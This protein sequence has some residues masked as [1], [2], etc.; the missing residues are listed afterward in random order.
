[1][2]KITHVWY[3]LQTVSSQYGMSETS[4]RAKKGYTQVLS[5]ESQENGNSPMEGTAENVQ[6][7]SGI[8]NF[9]SD[10]E[11]GHVGS[12]NVDFGLA[13]FRQSHSLCAWTSLMGPRTRHCSTKC[14]APDLFAFCMLWSPS[15]EE[16]TFWSAGHHRISIM[17]AAM[18]STCSFYWGHKTSP[19]Y[20]IYP[21]AASPSHPHCIKTALETINS[22]R[23]LSV[24][25][26]HVTTPAVNGNNNTLGL[27]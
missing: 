27:Q 23:Y 25:F 11:S 1:M 22:V 19:R 16:G 9:R 10:C 14:W 3:H 7:Y 6:I 18:M 21:L 13:W 12:C 20:A 24:I 26:L 5:W 4:C 8:H 17:H 2:A 15:N